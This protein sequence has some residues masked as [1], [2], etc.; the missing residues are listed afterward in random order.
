[1]T[2]AKNSD[3]LPPPPCHIQ[4]SADFVPF[5]CF[6][7]TA[8]PPPTA[9]VIYGSPQV[10]SLHFNL[11]FPTG[12]VASPPPVYGHPSPSVVLARRILFLLL[13]SFSPCLQPAD[14][15]TWPSRLLEWRLRRETDSEMSIDTWTRLREY[16]FLIRERLR[17]TRKFVS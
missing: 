5:V 10:H 9:D 16:V 7:G 13:P 8:L 2:S 11:F 3:F 17:K 12:G 4:K 6:L 15:L 1:M 14:L